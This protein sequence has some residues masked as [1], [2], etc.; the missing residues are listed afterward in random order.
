MSGQ[1]PPVPPAFKGRR[2]GNG[3]I[4]LATLFELEKI[5]D[6]TYQSA[7]PAYSPGGGVRAFGGHV[8]AQAVLAAAKTV[9]GGFVCHVR[10]Y[11]LSSL[12]PEGVKAVGFRL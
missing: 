2:N 7:Y 4:G 9:E 12:L 5:D 10:D 6:Q 8:Y 11:P 3:Y 1:A